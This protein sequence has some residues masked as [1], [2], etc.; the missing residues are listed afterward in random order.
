[1]AIEVGICLAEDDGVMLPSMCIETILHL[2]G[3]VV[4]VV[5]NSH[6]K[7]SEK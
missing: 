7:V 6:P 4:V 2:N 1:L 5:V 3:G